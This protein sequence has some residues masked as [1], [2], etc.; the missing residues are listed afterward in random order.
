[1]K[2]KVPLGMDAFSQR[3]LGLA[4]MQ[5][6]QKLLSYLQIHFDACEIPFTLSALCA[7]TLQSMSEWKIHLDRE[8]SETTLFGLK[9]NENTRF[10]WKKKYFM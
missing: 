1:M 2:P 6:Q 3:E 9:S 8:E 5:R 7:L 10:L 4:R